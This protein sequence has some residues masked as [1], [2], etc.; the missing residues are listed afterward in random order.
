MKKH[1]LLGPAVKYLSI[2][3]LYQPVNQVL[4]QSGASGSKTNLGAFALQYSDELLAVACLI[5]LVLSSAIG[6][7]YKT[8]VYGGKP[9]SLWL[10]APICVTG[11]FVAFLYSLYLDKSLT[12]LTPIWVGGVS[13][14]APAIIHLI[15]AALIKHFGFQAGIDPEV[16]EKLNTD[17]SAES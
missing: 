9:L 17:R 7:F 10:K 6:V 8:P 4:A 1:T 15:H 5:L 2:V 13:F 16:L 14:I 12:L 3:V 11:G